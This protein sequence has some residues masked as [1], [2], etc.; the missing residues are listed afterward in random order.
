MERYTFDCN[1]RH[2]TIAGEVA[3]AHVLY[4][5]AAIDQMADY[6]VH[7]S[8][9]KDMSDLT[10]AELSSAIEDGFRHEVVDL[11]GQAVWLALIEGNTDKL[12]RL[13]AVPP[14]ERSYICHPLDT[15]GMIKIGGIK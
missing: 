2:V 9:K 7:L 8:N 10:D 12:R 3:R 5:G 4:E 14:A 11:S 6:Y 15:D 1:A 13:L